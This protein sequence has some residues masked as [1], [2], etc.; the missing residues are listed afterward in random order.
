MGLK[1]ME[2]MGQM[3]NSEEATM[4]D[5]LPF[6][7]NDLD[8]DDEPEYNVGGFVPGTQQDQ[9]MGIVDTKLHLHLL[10]RMRHNLFK[11][12]QQFVQPE[13]AQHRHT[14]LHSKCLLLCPPLVKSPGR[15]FQ[16]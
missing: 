8:M 1:M 9:Q 16:R 13:P 4:P 11:Q 2:A 3:G 5:D 14:Y 6:D 7:I 15:V 12:S 10:P